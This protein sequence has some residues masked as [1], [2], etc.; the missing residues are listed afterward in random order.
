M[1]EHRLELMFPNDLVEAVK[2][3]PVFI[4]PC[5]L[6]E[7]HGN[8]LPLGQDALKA[9]GICLEVARKLGGGIVMPPNYYGRPG[10]STY[11]GTLTYSEEA[12]YPLFYETFAQLKKAGAKVIA[13]ITGH[14][15]PCQVDFVKKVA[16]DFMAANPGIHIIARPEYEGVLVDGAAPADHAGKWET[17]MFWAMHPDKI[18]W[19]TY[20]TKMRGMK[21][22]ESAPHDVYQEAAEWEFREDLRETSSVELGRRAVD[23]ISGKICADIQKALLALTCRCGKCKLC[24]PHKG[25]TPFNL[26]PPKES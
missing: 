1:T 21:I 10:F 5:G 26:H 20:E 15:G 22:Y 14:Y 8:H 7:W 9:H 11:A 12:L 16:A 24:R 18:R 3:M 6:L 2:K 13:L 17:S 23:A 4:M 19:E 25:E